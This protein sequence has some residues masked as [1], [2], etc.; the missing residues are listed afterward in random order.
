MKSSTTRRLI[1]AVEILRNTELIQAL[2]ID[3]LRT[4]EI[5][6]ALEEYSGQYGMQTFDQ[7]LLTL[8]DKHLIS[9]EDA[10]AYATKPKDLTLRI[11][12]IETL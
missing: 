5:M 2:I 3:P 9:Q 4:K 11:K 12:G 6:P 8:L 10:L 1:P 7:S